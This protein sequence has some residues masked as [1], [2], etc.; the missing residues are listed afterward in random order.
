ML[1]PQIRSHLQSLSTET[2]VLFGLEGHV[3]IY[4]STRDL[5]EMD[6]NVVLV[7]D[8]IASRFAEDRRVALDQLQKWGATVSTSESV[9]FE[10]IRDSTHEK[11]RELSNLIK[12]RKE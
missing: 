1:I 9:I 8:G 7:S 6:V 5:L 2:V 4:Q 11:F 10:L 12:A 3:C